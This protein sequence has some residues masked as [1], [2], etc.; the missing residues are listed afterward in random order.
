M[1]RAIAGAATAVLFVFASCGDSDKPNAAPTTAATATTALGG[2]STS[3]RD[4]AT[5]GSTTTRTA[6]N[7]T[8]TSVAT[9]G[10]TTTRVNPLELR[11]DG[12]GSLRIGRD[13]ANDVI[14]AIT[15]LFGA[16]DRDGAVACE[17]GSD[18]TVR[19]IAVDLT[20][21]FSKGIWAG[22]LYTPKRQ[23][24][25]TTANGLAVGSTVG[26]LKT[27]YPS[28]LQIFTG[29]LGPEFAAPDGLR[30]FATG[31]ADNAAITQLGA[32]DICAF[33]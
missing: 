10:A 9:T 4:T 23:P 6:V 27:T 15:N 3:T 26:A 30:G 19:W 1:H 12:I 7:L 20:A 22:Y 18:R 17:S 28:G 21:V 13:S 2:S 31:T 8:S 5:S 14:N 29:S 24:A 25:L 32:G 33:R 11:P 16:A